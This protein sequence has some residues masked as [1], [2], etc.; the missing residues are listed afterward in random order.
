MS[1][2][3]C[4]G[5]CP[6]VDVDI[7]SLPTTVLEAFLCHGPYLIGEQLRAKISCGLLQTCS[8][9]QDI[10]VVMSSQSESLNERQL[11]C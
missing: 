10:T 6:G 3:L 2:Y 7:V 1:S 8:C 11:A 4:S 9:C 5:R